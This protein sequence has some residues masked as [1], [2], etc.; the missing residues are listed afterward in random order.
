MAALK[1]EETY[2]GLPSKRTLWLDAEGRN[3]ASEDP[4]PFGLLRAV[5]ADKAT[6]SH[7]A[8][9]GGELP[10]EVYSGTIART[11]VRLPSSAA[12][13]PSSSPGLGTASIPGAIPPPTPFSSSS[14]PRPPRS[15]SGSGAGRGASW[16]GW[17]RFGRA[18]GAEL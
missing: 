11:Q 12:R 16:G 10:A 14:P 2:S 18:W 9:T 3:L 7:A 4:G 1:L 6:A 15:C 17:R 13:S 5:L 8:E